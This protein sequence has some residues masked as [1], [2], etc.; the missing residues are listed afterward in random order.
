[1]ENTDLPPDAILSE[2]NDDLNFGRIWML[3]ASAYTKLNFW[4]SAQIAYKQAK[5]RLESS[6]AMWSDLGICLNHLELG[7]L[8]DAKICVSDLLHDYTTN[9]E[10]D[11]VSLLY[12]KKYSYLSFYILFLWTCVFK[13]LYPILYISY[14]IFPGKIFNI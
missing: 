8:K 12:L 10:F 9:E 13:L 6:V 5:K 14:Q 11:I 4:E 3:L 1:M 2:I 7:N